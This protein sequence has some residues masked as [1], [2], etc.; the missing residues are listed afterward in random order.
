LLKIIPNIQKQI[1]I[2]PNPMLHP[3]APKVPG[4]LKETVS[5]YTHVPI[6]FFQPTLPAGPPSSA[7]FILT[8]INA[9]L[10]DIHESNSTLAMY[11]WICYSSQT[12]FY[13]G[14]ALFGEVIAT[15]DTSFLRWHLES[16]RKADPW[17]NIWYWS[18][19]FV[20]PA[21]SPFAPV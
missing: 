17:S 8:M 15:N 11:C 7:E 9:S 1:T 4:A 10:Q 16:K 13:K 2:G 20:T 5:F 18:L 21:G 3:A 19:S 12:P 6:T 14:I